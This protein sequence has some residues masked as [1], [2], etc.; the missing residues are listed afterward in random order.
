MDDETCNEHDSSEDL[1]QPFYAFDRTSGNMPYLESPDDLLEENFEEALKEGI[2][3]N[4][5][6]LEDNP[7]NEIESEQVEET[8]FS[9]ISQY[10]I[11]EVAGDDAYARKVITIYASRLP[12]NKILNHNNLLK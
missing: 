8:D 9:D 7:C 10:G 2:F 6:S 3:H 4:S 12:S 11:V 1:R 5:E